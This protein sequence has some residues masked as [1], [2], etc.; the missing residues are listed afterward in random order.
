MNELLEK[1]WGALTP[2]LL[3]VMAVFEPGRLA[4]AAIRHEVSAWV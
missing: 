3:V 2:E 4:D 1:L